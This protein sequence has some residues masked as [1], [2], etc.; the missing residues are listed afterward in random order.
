[1]RILRRS[2]LSPRPAF[3]L[4]ELMVVIVIVG[5]LA[6]LTILIFPKLQYS[7]SVAKGAD[8]VQGQLYLAKQ[9]ALRD[10]L[11]RGVRFI[12]N[13]AAGGF[14]SVQLIEQP[15]PYNKGTISTLPTAADGPGPTSGLW[16]VNFSATVNSDFA[17]GAVLAGDFLDLSAAGDLYTVNQHAMHKIMAVSWV[18]GG[19]LPAPPASLP[20]V[21]AP[22]VWLLS[23]PTLPPTPTP[24]PP[25]LNLPYK[26][27][28]APR[29][30]IGVGP[31]AL[32]SDI[33]VDK[34]NDPGL[35]GQSLITQDPTPSGAATFPP[36]VGSN[37]D[38]MFAPSG[39]V[40]GLA[41]TQGKVVLWIWDPTRSA[42]EQVLVAVFTQTGNI[43]TQPVNE[44]AGGD[45]YLFIKDG[46]TSGM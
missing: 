5:I 16:Q 43:A 28:R 40:L 15:R 38:I 12:P 41:G 30:M 33:F 14:D 29:P 36:A 27:V 18:A 4:V 39:K 24:L 17:N 46:T 19:G 1:M 35:G 7:Q 21:A 31:V 34:G 3:T 42:P 32:P 10:Q 22:T 11:P 26:I 9:M 8:V 2:P 20:A 45:P 25:P 13:A 23:Q 44:V 37:Y 6:A